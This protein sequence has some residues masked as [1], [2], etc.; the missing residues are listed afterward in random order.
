MDCVHLDEFLVMIRWRDSAA[1]ACRGP[2]AP[3]NFVTP[4]PGR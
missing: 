3:S 4:W 1:F 2:T